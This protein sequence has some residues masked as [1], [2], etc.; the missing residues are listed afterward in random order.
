MAHFLPTPTVDKESLCLPKMYSIAA[1]H[2]K[3]TCY[4]LPTPKD[5]VKS[6]TCTTK[7]GPCV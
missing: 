1:T 5:K 2:W 6:F 7:I 3:F 4:Q